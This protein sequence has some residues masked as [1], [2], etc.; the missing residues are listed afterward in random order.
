MTG[1]GDGERAHAVS[2]SEGGAEL[3]EGSGEGSPPIDSDYGDEPVGEDEAYAGAGEYA[4]GERP[5]EAGGERRR[6][7]G[8]RGGRRR[9]RDNGDGS[10]RDRPPR[11]PGSWEQPSAP[12]ELTTSNAGSAHDEAVPYQATSPRSL[13]MAAPSE[14]PVAVAPPSPQPEP[15]ASPPPPPPPAAVPSISADTPPEKPKRG[16]WRR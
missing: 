13:P 10:F 3:S 16:W 12:R 1:D 9:R 14:A 8:R 6:R 15:A 2:G 11:E 7:R 4:E 5:D